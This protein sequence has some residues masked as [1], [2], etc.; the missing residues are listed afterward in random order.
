MVA[1]PT[2]RPAHVRREQRGDL[3][4][5]SIG[6]NRATRHPASITAPYTEGWE[7]RCSPRAP[8][9][10]RAARSRVRRQ[11]QVGSHMRMC[12]CSHGM[13]NAAHTG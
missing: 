10:C 3:L 6:Q 1:E 4:P 8:V 9:V 5:L 13:T 2:T 7:T 11:I 12:H